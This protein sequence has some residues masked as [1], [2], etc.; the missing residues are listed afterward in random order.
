MI[1]YTLPPIRVVLEWVR[2]VKCVKCAGPH[3]YIIFL[4]VSWIAQR[5]SRESLYEIFSRAI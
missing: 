4:S 3:A 5:Q 2:C 1:C